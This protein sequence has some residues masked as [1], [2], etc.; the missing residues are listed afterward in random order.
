MILTCPHCATHYKVAD[1]RLPEKSCKV[2]CAACHEE[3]T[4][5]D[6]ESEIGYFGATGT[7][8]AGYMQPVR[9]SALGRSRAYIG[10]P[11]PRKPHPR[12]ALAALYDSFGGGEEV[13]APVEEVSSGI[14]D[15][16]GES[17]FHDEMEKV[18]SRE[19]A[20]MAGESRALVVQGQG[21]DG[22]R[23]LAETVKTS[24][25]SPERE[26]ARELFRLTSRLVARQTDRLASRIEDLLSA[27]L[28][29]IPRRKGEGEPFRPSPGD[30]EVSEFRA[31]YRQRQKNRMTPMRFFGWL[32]WAGA[33]GACIFAVVTMQNQIV[34]VFPPAGK[35]YA[36]FNGSAA[37]KTVDVGRLQ[38]RYA[39]SDK[40][41][42]V[43]LR[44][45][46]INKGEKA[47]AMPLLQADA[48]DA[49]GKVLVSWVFRVG[50]A[51]QM[52]PQMEF[53]FMTR[54][55]APDGIAGLTVRTLDPAEADMFDL[56][57][58][59]TPDV[60]GEDGFYLQKTD[61]GWSRGA[62][63]PVAPSPVQ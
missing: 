33:L 7:D 49:E 16:D 12:D 1:D 31:R 18:A 25:T 56:P 44:G 8:G 63:E 53:P 26:E 37:E 9:P 27:L 6:E 55:L 36:V 41:P 10:T 35:A 42:V 58:A 60:P 45:T 17:P 46:L 62:R 39:M 15:R 43:E 50:N 14:R 3:W 57:P 32:G 34:E 54:S 11:R 5:F 21:G 29:L 61:P 47:V 51:R 22:G 28:R 30:M 38:H 20:D 24:A 13:T 48:V 19:D 2:K 52:Q 4:L 40:G 59:D 23:E